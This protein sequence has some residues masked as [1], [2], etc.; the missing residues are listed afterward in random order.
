MVADVVARG[1]ALE[2]STPAKLV[3][4]GA[5]SVLGSSATAIP[6][7]GATG[8]ATLFTLATIV[9]T[10]PELAN[11]VLRIK[12]N[13]DFLLPNH[14]GRTVKVLFNGVTVLQS[15]PVASIG[16]LATID[17][18]YIMPDLSGVAVM[19]PNMNNVLAPTNGQG[20]PFIAQTSNTQTVTVDMTGG[21]TITIEALP[22]NNDTVQLNGFTV[23]QL[24][25]PAASP[26]SSPANATALWG[27]SLYAGTGTEP[28]FLLN[29]TGN[30]STGTNTIAN[31]GSI[32]GVL[33]GQAILAAGVPTGAY[34]TNATGTTITMSENATATTT[35]VA[36]SI[37]AG[38]VGQRMLYNNPGQAFATNAYP[39]Q[40]SATILGHM[41]ANVS[42]GKYWQA[43]LEAGRNDVGNPS[44]PAVIVANYTAMA[45]NL[46][47][48]VKHFFN[49]IIP[50]AN[51][52]PSSTNY[53]S[54]VAANAAII[55]AFG[56]S[57]V[58]DIFSALTNNGTTNIALKY[59]N[60]ITTTGTITSGTAALTV[61]SGTGIVAGMYCVSPG[62]TAIS[63]GDTDTAPTVISA[64]GTAVVLSANASGNLSGAMVSF[65][66][67]AEVHLNDGGYT[68]W[69]AVN[70]AT[71]A[72]LGM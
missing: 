3:A 26:I 36:T 59:R 55:A 15:F 9:V 35:G 19:T 5:I 67:P 22:T 52:P 33:N 14:A 18:V 66:N 42:Q 37:Q 12:T 38:K 20:A 31:V 39:G 49:T 44:L 28:A 11:S 68:I 21:L 51:E 45:A 29:T 32:T 69:W 41:V 17:D 53:L 64:V 54:I 46:A 25:Q 4:G 10:N 60:A 65:V 34:V 8:N 30:I 7:F 23:E 61:A 70:Q 72:A 24:I 62:N 48:G 57:L 16:G 6:V 63:R 43:M 40:T 2:A 27:D 71:K 58:S 13:W 1:L 47:A 56:A 50:A